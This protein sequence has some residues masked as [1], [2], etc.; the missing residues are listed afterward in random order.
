MAPLAAAN[1]QRISSA[2][3]SIARHF[4]AH[5]IAPLLVISCSVCLAI[6]ISANHSRLAEPAFHGAAW[7]PVLLL[8]LRLS[9]WHAWPCAIGC[10]LAS[11]CAFAVGERGD[12]MTA[13]P[14]AGLD[15]KA[16]HEHISF[17]AGSVIAVTFL[18][19][20]AAVSFVLLVALPLTPFPELTGK[21]KTIGTIG[22]VWTRALPECHL[23][24]GVGI[25]GATLSDTRRIPVQ[26]F[27]PSDV[28]EPSY[29][30][31]ALIW[32]TGSSNA[33]KQLRDVLQEFCTKLLYW[34]EWIGMRP[35][36]HFLSLRSRFVH[37]APL[38]NDQERW[39][40]VV[41]SHGLFGWKTYNSAVCAEVA[42]RGVVVVALDHVGDSICSATGDGHPSQHFNLFYDGP[43]FTRLPLHTQRDVYLKTSQV[44]HADLIHVGRRLVALS[45]QHSS[46]TPSTSRFTADDVSAEPGQ[47]A[48][49]HVTR[50]I[51]GRVLGN[52]GLVGH[53]YGAATCVCA[54]STHGNLPPLPNAGTTAALF[55]SALASLPAAITA[56]G[57]HS[58]PR[59]V[60]Q[61]RK[62]L[63]SQ[64]PKKAALDTL[65]A[66]GSP[67]QPLHQMV[68]APVPLA[69]SLAV[70][71]A[72]PSFDQPWLREPDSS[73]PAAKA[74]W[75]PH[76][77]APEPRF[78]SCV[79]L[80]P[81]LWAIDERYTLGYNPFADCDGFGS[82]CS[83]LAAAK[84]MAEHVPDPTRRSSSL[85]EAAAAVGERHRGAATLILSSDKDGWNY[86]PYQQPFAFALVDR[87]RRQWLAA[88]RQSSSY[89]PAADDDGTTS[90]WQRPVED[91][92]HMPGTGHLNFTDLPLLAHP[93]FMRRAQKIGDADPIVAMADVA[94]RTADF[95]QHHLRLSEVQ[96]GYD[97]S[98]TTSVNGVKA[99]QR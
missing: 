84:W 26:I 61:R 30:S 60:C 23:N 4:S 89:H 66:Q 10:V 5:A 47:L 15:V 22:D 38:S 90:T 97:L 81:F 73:T 96:Q 69:P 35:M 82:Q 17:G 53:S 87:M 67:H 31:R 45:K 13:S 54:I 57:S 92:V 21:Y 50:T 86:G 18:L 51:G 7:L 72:S 14:L 39:P 85:C 80:D 12:S 95:L 76:P 1:N 44:R 68:A 43:A 99:R 56:S 98:P 63:S 3:A 27:Y 36:A 19:L 94:N 29:F 8:F 59:S 52:F 83:D 58:S 79:A 62:S 11:I 16:M 2:K 78:S 32:T 93:W 88:G 20:G 41:Y 64:N 49:D 24:M 55:D 37:N 33:E 25:V 28:R 75:R 34:P 71:S 46:V 74:C 48:S 70:A 9:M 40:V 42:S 65:Q 77:L 6:F 91:L